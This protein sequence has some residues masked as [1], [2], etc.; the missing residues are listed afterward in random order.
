MEQ[1][2]P[3]R[4]NP[5]LRTIPPLATALALATGA[6][7]ALTAESPDPAAAAALAL[8][9]LALN[10]EPEP[11]ASSTSASWDR[12]VETEIGQAFAQGKFSFNARLRWEHADQE[13]LKA[14]DAVT[15]RPRFGFTTAPA[16]G[17]Q[18]ML[19]A[20]NITSLGAPY[21]PAGLDPDQTDR[22]VIADP[23]T[24]EINQAWIAYSRWDSVARYGR[25]RLLLDNER[26][27]GDVGWRQNQQTFDGV[28]VRS[29]VLPETSLLYGYLTRINRVFG[30]AHPQGNWN[31]DSHLVHA[32]R[33]L[34]PAARLTG[35]GYFLN[36]DDAVTQSTTTAG[37][38]LTGSLKPATDLSLEYRAE[39]A[40]QTGGRNHPVD[41]DALYTNLELTA[42][43]DRWLL[44]GGYELLGSHREVG[45][46]TPL[47]TLHRFNGWADAFLAT[48]ADGLQDLWVQAGVN[49]PLNIPFRVIYHK[50]WSHIDGRDYGQ[51]LD[52]LLSRKFGRYFTT[53]AKYAWYEGGSGRP[54]L[55]RF[56]L[57]AEFNY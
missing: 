38:S 15:I 13:G 22:T 4:I 21:N 46:T 20:E 3:M 55:Q 44:G 10:P 7:T 31:S 26:F 12:L 49:L 41:Y 39:F 43:Y 51:E 19:E 50:F 16:Y 11:A 28:V 5:P 8:P 34:C 1:P 47:A 32:S 2:L 53:L 57:Q 33:Q 52:L 27:V 14:S 36:F 24:T 23:E 40:W 42:S 18:G 48:P 6:V 30:D 37:A 25:Q 29:E 35:Y 56:W 45:F 54:D 17:F 9:A